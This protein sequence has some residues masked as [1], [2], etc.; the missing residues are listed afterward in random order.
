LNARCNCPACETQRVHVALRRHALARFRGWHGG[1]D[2]DVV[3]G[4]IKFLRNAGAEFVPDARDVRVELLDGD[5]AGCFALVERDRATG[6]KRIVVDPRSEFYV[7]AQRGFHLGLAALL[8]HE[9]FHLRRGADEE[10]AYRAHVQFLE[11]QGARP[12]LIQFVRTCGAKACA[13]EA[14]LDVD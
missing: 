11:Q 1:Q 13:P 3:L 9:T 2:D 12:A 4:A 8:L 6:K 5:D 14:V 7:S 10:P